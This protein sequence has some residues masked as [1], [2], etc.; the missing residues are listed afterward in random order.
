MLGP[1]SMGYDRSPLMYS[2]EG[3]IIQTE[4]ARESVRRGSIAI[5]IKSTYGVV[6]AGLLRVVDLNEPDHK[7]HKIAD[8]IQAIFAGVAA[9]GRI[10]ISKARLESE[11]FR[12]TYIESIDVRG[13]AIKIGDY[14]QIFTQQGG[15]RPFGVGM[16]FGGIDQ[17]GPSLQFVDPGGGVVSCKAKAMGEGD[18]EAIAYL[19]E[20]YTDNLTIDEMVEIA[21]ESIRKAARD[22]ELSDDSIVIEVINSDA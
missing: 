6:L 8:S 9:D 1:Q 7:I 17:T 22:T 11:I 4:Y 20:K 13:L 16:L 15:L 10:L 18:S 19:K 12:L 2:P 14:I 3:R 5:G 21:K